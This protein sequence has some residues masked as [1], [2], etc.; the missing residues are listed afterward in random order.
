MVTRVG[1][2]RVCKRSAHRD[3]PVPRGGALAG[4]IFGGS[5]VYAHTSDVEPPKIR[6][7]NTHAWRRG[8]GVF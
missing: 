4:P 7:G 6:R 1:E 8:G 2:G 5:L 3:A